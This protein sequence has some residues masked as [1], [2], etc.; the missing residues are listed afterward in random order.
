ML[1]ALCKHPVTLQVARS[2]S[3]PDAKRAITKGLLQRI[4][5]SAILKR[6]DRMELLA[7]ASTVFHEDLGFG[8]DESPD[9]AEEIEGLERILS[10]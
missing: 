3:F 10:G 5:L 1:T 8:P 6:A 2:L 9:W 7:R 4:D